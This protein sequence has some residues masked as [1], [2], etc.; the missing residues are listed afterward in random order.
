MECVVCYGT[1]K[2]K[3]SCNHYVCNDCTDRMFRLDSVNKELCPICRQARTDICL[4]CKAGNELC[5]CN[6]KYLFIDINSNKWF[7]LRCRLWNLI[8]EFYVDIKDYVKI[9]DEIGEYILFNQS[10][11]EDEE[12]ENYI[13]YMLREM[14]IVIDVNEYENEYDQSILINI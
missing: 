13:T 4:R 2:H 6:I 7:S 12:R 1:T 9:N 3:T 8:K 10:T 11:T 5:V 14:N